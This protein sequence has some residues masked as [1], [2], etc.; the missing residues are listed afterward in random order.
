MYLIGH[1]FGESIEG[2]DFFFINVGI[3]VSLRVPRLILLALK[4]TTI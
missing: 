1:L 4:L 3:L 2:Y